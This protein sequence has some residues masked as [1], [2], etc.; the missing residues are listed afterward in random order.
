ML[1]Y[2]VRRLLI[3]LLTL[4]MI[5]FVIYGLIR[6]MPGDATTAGMSEDL[7]H[8]ISE[9]DRQQMRAIYGLDD[10]LPVG[11]GKWLNN[12]LHG[13]L[14]FS[15]SQKDSVSRILWA[16]IGPTLLLSVNSLL[17]TYLFSVPMGLYA[18]ARSNSA[19]ERAMSVG[20]YILYSFPTFA[21][22]V[23]LQ[24]VLAVRFEWFPLTGNRSPNYDE[25]SFWQ[26]VLD[27]AHHAVLP[28]VCETYVGLAYYSRFVRSNLMEVLRQDYIRTARAK[29]CDE[30]RVLFY[31]A[32]RN[33]MI[34][35]VTLVGLTLPALLSGSVIIERI[36]NWPGLGLMLFESVAARDR[37]LIMAITF[38]YAVL[39]L[40]GTLLSDI[41]Y[42]VVDPRITY[43]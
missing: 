25:L 33:T 29:G 36:F 42:A 38:L 8:K 14:G 10:P 17:L 26:R 32:L 1:H 22:A 6:A 35:L 13:D 3:G 30:R 41:L 11:Y 9:K 16:K 20:L 21:A 12:V 43:S 2:L 39:A 5:T 27:M 18:A 7:S 23:L 34:P 31:H 15:R 40:L 28:L 4:V 24:I 19:S 37:E